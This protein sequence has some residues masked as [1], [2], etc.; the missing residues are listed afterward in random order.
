MKGGEEEDY[1]ELV[2][3]FE[4][5]TPNKSHFKR[6]TLHNWTV[7]A[8]IDDDIALRPDE[9]I[10]ELNADLLNNTSETG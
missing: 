4:P 9:I 3:N 1:P 2:S 7:V 10:E 6:R 5:S 8:E